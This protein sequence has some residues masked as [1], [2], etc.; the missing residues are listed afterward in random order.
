M[1]TSATTNVSY[2]LPTYDI[3]KDWD[4]ST[5][6]SFLRKKI[7][8]YDQYIDILES[9]FINGQAFFTLNIEV[10]T[11]YPFNLPYGVAVKIAEWVKRLDKEQGNKLINTSGSILTYLL[12]ISSIFIF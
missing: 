3:V 8:N 2:T 1:S 5:L 9:Q 7:K 4:M 6:I 12:D 11:N 10:L